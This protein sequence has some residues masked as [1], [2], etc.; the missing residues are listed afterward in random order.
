MTVSPAMQRIYIVLARIPCGR[1]VSYGQLADLAGLPGRA[2]LAG[3]ALRMLPSQ[4]SLPW[5]R[6]L[7]SNGQLAFA[8]NSEAF[9]NQQQLLAHE[10][11]V[12]KNGR[13]DMR[14]NQW[15]PTLG[16]LLTVAL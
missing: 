8:A 9:I 6:V 10:G 16:E 2:R 1:V 5:H 7:R 11:I 15:R 4:S 3:T 13:V 14:Q 12:V